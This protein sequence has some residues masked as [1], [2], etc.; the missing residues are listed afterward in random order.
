MNMKEGMNNYL[1]IY[2]Q[3]RRKGEVG[4][5]QSFSATYAHRLH[6]GM[7][8]VFEDHDEELFGNTKQMFVVLHGNINTKNE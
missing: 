2:T 3:K 7:V 1:M 5:V 6:D 8:S 4:F